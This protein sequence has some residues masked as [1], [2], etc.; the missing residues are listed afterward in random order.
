MLQGEMRFKLSLGQCKMMW[1]LYVHETEMMQ[2][3]M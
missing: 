2:K 3:E 1:D